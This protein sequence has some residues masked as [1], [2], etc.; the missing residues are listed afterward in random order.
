MDVVPARKV[1]GFTL[2]PPPRVIGKIHLEKF[3]AMPGQ[4]YN[5]IPHRS[6][7]NVYAEQAKAE[8]IGELEQGVK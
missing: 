2:P 7:S 5:F 1:E 6:L 4:S 3:S 8:L